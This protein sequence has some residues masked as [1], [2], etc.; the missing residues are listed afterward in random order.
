MI[1]LTIILIMT[2][3]LGGYIIGRILRK[4]CGCYK[5]LRSKYLHRTG[6]ITQNRP[7][8]THKTIDKND[9][10]EKQYQD[11]VKEPVGEFKRRKVISK[12]T[13]ICHKCGEEYDIKYKTIENE[14]KKE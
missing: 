12:A 5:G 11:V 8:L 4:P 14:L 2:I 13:F 9:Y 3:M 1:E 10:L 7:E 6:K